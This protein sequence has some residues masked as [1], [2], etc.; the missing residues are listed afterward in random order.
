MPEIPGAGSP[1]LPSGAGRPRASKKMP[2][3]PRMSGGT[4]P[5]SKMP[6]QKARGA[7]AKMGGVKNAAQSARNAFSKEGR[8]DLV[9][10]AGATVAEAA[11]AATTVAKKA[12]TESSEG[13]RQKSHPAGGS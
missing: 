3:R 6:H 10:Q 13:S 7:K 12:A 1:K 4:P 8:R 11:K 2:S 9:R 5:K